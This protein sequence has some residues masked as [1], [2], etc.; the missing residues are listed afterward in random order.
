MKYKFSLDRAHATTRVDVPDEVAGRIR[1]SYYHSG[2]SIGKLSE[3]YGYG[4]SVIE[5]ILGMR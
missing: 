3:L 4:T 2:L 5:R 1:K